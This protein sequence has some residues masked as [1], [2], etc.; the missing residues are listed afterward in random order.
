VSLPI[1]NNFS[2]YIKIPK[3]KNHKTEGKCGLCNEGSP[4]KT[5]RV[6]DT[7]PPQKP[8]VMWTLIIDLEYLC[9]FLHN[10]EEL[11][12]QCGEVDDRD[13]NMK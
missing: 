5:I 9:K 7:G 2:L 11:L 6:Q 3:D 1:S 10:K 13:E 12:K 4:L 8:N